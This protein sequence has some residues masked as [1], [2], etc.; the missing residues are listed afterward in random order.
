MS[1]SKMSEMEQFFQ[2]DRSIKAVHLEI[3]SSSLSTRDP[4]TLKGEAMAT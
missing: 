1:I 4:S 3:I 2:V